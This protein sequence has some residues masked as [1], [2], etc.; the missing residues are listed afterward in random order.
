MQYREDVAEQLEMRIIVPEG[1]KIMLK[2]VPTAAEAAAAAAAGPPKKQVR[3]RLSKSDEDVDVQYDDIKIHRK[4]KR[5]KQSSSSSTKNNDLES[6]E[7]YTVDEASDDGGDDD[8]DDDGTDLEMEEV[9]VH[10]ER[11]PNPKPN[12]AKVCYHCRFESESGSGIKW[13]KRDNKDDG[14]DGDSGWECSTCRRYR[15]AHAGELR[16]ARLFN[17]QKRRREAAA[18]ATVL[19]SSSTPLSAGIIKTPLQRSRFTG[20]GTRAALTPNLI[21]SGG[22]ACIR[23]NGAAGRRLTSTSTRTT[24]RPPVMALR[25]QERLNIHSAR[26]LKAT[27]RST[28]KK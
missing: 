12:D 4:P 10:K 28:R 23:G 18:A 13:M 11:V 22:N 17:R 5:F 3:F 7:E 2:K 16:P 25:L 27:M 21:L 6:E 19:G 9:T 8:D 20:A 14:E 15:Q 24:T 1:T 26:L